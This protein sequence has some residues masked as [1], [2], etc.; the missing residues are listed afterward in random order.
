MN[1]DIRLS[2]DAPE[3]WKRRVLFYFVTPFA[4]VAGASAVAQAYDTSWIADNQ[5]V[6]ASALKANLD[7]IQT[8]ITALENASPRKSAFLAHNTTA[9]LVPNQIEPTIV[10][11]AEAFDLDDEYDPATGVFTTKTGGYYDI[12]C[13]VIFE[14]EQTSA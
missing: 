1:I 14:S 10:F 9:T 6:S 12:S 8:R 13:N 4:L 5:P 3:G 2:L 11:D 7:E